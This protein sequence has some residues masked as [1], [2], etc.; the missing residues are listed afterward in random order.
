MRRFP[1]LYY[2]IAIVTAVIVFSLI[3]L[4]AVNCGA[5]EVLN[6]EDC[7]RAIIGEASNQGEIG[8]L[9]LAVGIRNRGS[10]RGV[11]GFN[12]THIDNEPAWVWDMARKAWKE[13][14][15]NRI[16]NGY[17]WENILAFGEPSWYNDVVEVYRHKDHVFFVEKGK[18]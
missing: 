18:L 9:A 10:L 15:E 2:F 7:I 11:Y 13:S 17:M 8:M 6:A 12:S 4:V 5:D 3:T 14:K 1:E 16:H